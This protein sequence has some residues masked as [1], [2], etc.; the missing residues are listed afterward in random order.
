MLIHSAL[1]LVFCIIFFFLHSMPHIQHMSLGWV[2]LVGAVLLIILSDRHDME[3]ILSHV[4]WTTLL[5]FAALF[6]LVETVA[7]LGVIDWIGKQ[8]ETVV[9]M[10]S[11]ES[12]LAVAIVII[13]WVS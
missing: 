2:A 7:L 12:R 9:M 3:A 6:I 11:N 5:F 8:T 10:V 1:T 4:E 13:L